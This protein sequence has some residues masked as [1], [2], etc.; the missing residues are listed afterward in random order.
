MRTYIKKIRDQALM[1][2]VTPAILAVET[3]DNTD[4]SL[5][6]QNLDLYYDH[7]HMEYYYFCQQCKDY[8]EVVRLLDHKRVS[9]AAGFLKDCIL[10]Q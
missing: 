3:R 7:S 8:F 6:P 4:R 1:A 10:N 5:K 2:S 9:F